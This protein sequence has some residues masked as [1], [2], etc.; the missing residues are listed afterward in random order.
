MPG[1]DEQPWKT[2]WANADD[3][4]YEAKAQGRNRVVLAQNRWADNWY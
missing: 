1:P 4:L 2:C 3:A